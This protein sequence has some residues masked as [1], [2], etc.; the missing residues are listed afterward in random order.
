MQP[1]RNSLLTAILIIFAGMLSNILATVT[2]EFDQCLRDRRSR[3]SN[4]TVML[5]DT[6]R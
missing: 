5:T 4:P 6:L 1:K 3:K 2:S